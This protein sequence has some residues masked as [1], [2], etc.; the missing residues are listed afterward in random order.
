MLIFL[1]A[2][3]A[4]SLFAAAGW[5]GAAILEGEVGAETPG[6]VLAGNEGA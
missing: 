2:F 4:V 1:S 5:A 6:V 3:D